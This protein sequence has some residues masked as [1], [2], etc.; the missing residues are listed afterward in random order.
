MHCHSP[1]RHPHYLS[2]MNAI[3]SINLVSK[4][5]PFPELAR[6]IE[7]R[8]KGREMPF[9][10]RLLFRDRHTMLAACT[11]NYFWAPS[12]CPAGQAL[13]VCPVLHHLAKKPSNAS[14]L[15]PS[16]DPVVSRG[17]PTYGRENCSYDRFG[18][19]SQVTELGSHS[20]LSESWAFLPHLQS[21]EEETSPAGPGFWE[22][23]CQG[24][25]LES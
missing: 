19:F 13:Y 17:I 10:K 12:G 24:L 18:N 1:L 14:S 7:D 2:Q 8:R 9:P 11:D 20:H 23:G 15:C 5:V 25:S 21:K 3:A 4:V 16:H 22:W 6:I